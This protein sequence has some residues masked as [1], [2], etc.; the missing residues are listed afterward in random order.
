MSK[1]VSQV[2]LSVPQTLFHH[3]GE[4]DK[5]KHYQVFPSHFTEN[6]TLLRSK[7]ADL[8]RMANA[9]YGARDV[10]CKIFTQ[11]LVQPH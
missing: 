1:D 3:R 9:V 10:T 4:Q 6:Q 8:C 5:Q 7:E 2:V 11:T